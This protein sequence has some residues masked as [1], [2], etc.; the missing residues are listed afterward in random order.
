MPSFRTNITTHEPDLYKAAIAMAEQAEAAAL[1]A[2]LSGRLVE[3]VR[4]RVSQ[5]NG[6]AFCLRAHTND[7]LAKNETPERLAVLPAWRETS[8]FSEI[9]RDALALAEQVTRIADAPAPDAVGAASSPLTAAQAAA[10]A[11]VAI[12][13][14][15]FNRIAITSHYA[16][17][18]AA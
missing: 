6:C 13:I 17:K 2:G 5:L 1:D 8:Y 7:A 4:I 18:P 12:T 15:T 11:W 16:V 3:L 14:N 9:E 10:V